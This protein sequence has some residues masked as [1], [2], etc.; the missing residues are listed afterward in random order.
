MKEN[1]PVLLLRKLVLLPYQELRIELNVDLSKKIMDLS[2]QAYNSKL[3]VICPDN[4]LESSPSE[5]DLPSVGILTKIKSKIILPNGNYR[6]VLSGLNRV[7]VNEYRN[8]PDEPDI[9]E[10]NV[11]RIY[12][13]EASEKE[14]EAVLRTLKAL[15][16]KYMSLNPA[17][18]NSVNNTIS[19]MT[20]LD[21]LTDVVANYLPLDIKKK[22]QYMNEFDYLTRA[23]NL[24][25]DIN[26]ELEVI[27]IESKIDEEIRESFEKEQR[28]LILKQKVAKLNEELGINTDKQTEVSHYRSRIDKMDIN[29]KIKAK[30]FDE[31][32]KY[33][34]TSDYSPDSSVIR[35]YLDT[36]IDLPWNTFS[37][38]EPDLDKIKATLDKNHYG[39][40]SVK[41][42][43]LEYIAIK[44]KASNVN[45]P[46]LCL[47]G[48]PGVGKT[49][50]GISISS[51]LNKEFYKISVGGLNDASELTGHKRTYLGSSPGKIM[52]GIKKCGTS[53]PVIL[54]DEVDKIISDFKGDPSAVLLDILDPN[55]NKSFIDNY[56][57]EPF[58]L[59]KVLFILT[60]N[61]VH[62]I[63]A[64]L[65]DRLEIIEINSYTEFEK[66]D[67]AKSYIIP[68][69]QEEYGISK[70]KIADKDIL[71]IINDYTKE[72]G[73]RE[74]R[75]ILEKIFRNITISEVKAKTIKW[76]MLEKIL[77]P[78]KYHNSV[79]KNN[80]PG[81][82]CALG[83]SPYGGVLI[84]FESILLSGEEGITITGNVEDSV[85][86]SANIAYKY[87]LSMA[88]HL[89]LNTKRIKGQTIHINALN[90]GIKKDGT[91]G[92]IALA[93]AII[94]LIL[95]ECVDPYTCFTGEMSLHG[96]VSKVGGVKEKIIGAFNSG[97]KRV[98]IPEDNSVDLLT[99]PEEI[100]NKIEIIPV[101]KYEE[102][103]HILFK[104]H[105]K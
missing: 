41:E 43:I 6:V 2:E 17:A 22:V 74:L 66:L 51:A 81:S 79:S 92:G 103:Y 93:S 15:L 49:T 85:K 95:D 62:N 96:D 11:K 46:I 84:H 52:Q 13:D 24:I 7:L 71:K 19:N 101:K 36:I 8:I 78:Q 83:V 18:S 39:L 16:E 37:K 102:I 4:V 90:Y 72:S 10:S 40:E 28:D 21:M 77:G 38:D 98:F 65:R 35:N 67:I 73:V 45:A 50:L 53:N 59:S 1:L 63:P 80:Y 97:Y 23:N 44:K 105:K 12:I 76:S 42:R 26:L 91:S 86:D 55:Q 48:P 32:K 89:H 31:V 64:A 34:Y 9:L 20:D 75:R 47:V 30:L 57:E 61:D 56:I 87:V 82:V 68:N 88:D 100:K 14:E 99:V 54:I 5:A 60:A 3:L 70:Y 29:P 58:D 69:I 25:K 104:G 27:S 33:A 94:S